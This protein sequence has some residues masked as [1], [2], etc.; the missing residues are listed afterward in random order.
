M[1]KQQVIQMLFPNRSKS[2]LA[3]IWQDVFDPVMSSL[4]GKAEVNIV[5]LDDWLK[6]VH[7]D[8]YKDDMSMKDFIELKLGKNYGEHLIE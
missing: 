1:N 4:S 8:E 3:Y 5:K 2:E 7:K 6:K